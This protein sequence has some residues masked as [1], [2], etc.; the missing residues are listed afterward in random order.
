LARV[1]ESHIFECPVNTGVL[2]GSLNSF[3]NNHL[4]LSLPPFNG[5]T[6]CFT[7]PELVV[8]RE[9]YETWR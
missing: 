1:S 4:P 9:A 3:W 6:E 2:E 8:T 5:T 7:S